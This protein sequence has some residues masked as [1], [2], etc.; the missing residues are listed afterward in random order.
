MEELVEELNVIQK[1]PKKNMNSI[2]FLV[3]VL[4]STI[5]MSFYNISV[6]K[7]IEKI[8]MNIS[9]IDD[10]INE[11]K[12]DKKLQIFSLLESNNNVI[13]SYKMMNKITT[14]INH[15]NVIQAKYD[16]KFKWFSLNNWELFS[17]IEIVSDNKAIAYQKTRDFLKWYRADSKALFDLDF[18]NKI[19]WMDDMKFKA[20][21][22]IKN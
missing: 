14:Y 13:N 17:D 15:M 2:V 5:L 4:L 16:L 12:Q 19:E 9:S 1:K 3:I 11:V 18:V 20:H 8:K 6:K 22:K 7:D 10:S 21:F